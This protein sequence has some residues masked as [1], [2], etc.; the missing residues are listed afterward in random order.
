M[1]EHSDSQSSLRQR[2]FKLL[3]KN[4]LWKP[5]ELCIILKLDYTRSHRDVIQQY[6]K[7]WKKEYQLQQGLIRCVPDGVHNA[8]FRGVLGCGVGGLG[9][10]WVRS[11]ARNSFWVYRSGLGRIRFFEG[12]G[13]VELFVRKPSSIGKAM[14]LFCDAFVKPGFV[15]AECID[16]FR[17][18]LMRRF[19]A[20][21]DV[22]E[23][24]KYMRVNA[25]KPTHRFE[26][27]AGDKSHPTC[28]E[29][30]FE[31]QAEVE[32]ARML[33]EKIVDTFE[34]FKGNGKVGKLNVKEFG[35]V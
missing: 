32:Q 31:Y 25:F 30:M 23:R 14:Q 10:P 26:F 11:R 29:F 16:G 5:K 15:S 4:P 34:L 2:V 13:T 7:Q 9:L 21:F 24:L 12:T 3:S 35:V 22:G 1:S 20:T 33:V 19:H 18:T 27:V 8:F 28:Y 17:K 6:K